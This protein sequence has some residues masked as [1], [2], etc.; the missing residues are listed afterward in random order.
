MR[1][2]AST[3]PYDQYIVYMEK[4]EQLDASACLDCIEGGE[5]FAVFGNNFICGGTSKANSRYSKN[6][7][8]HGEY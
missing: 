1:Q 4:G 6:G 8:F 7:N 3:N 5:T 2:S